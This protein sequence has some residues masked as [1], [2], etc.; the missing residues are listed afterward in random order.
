M[1]AECFIGF[2]DGASRHTCNLASA[3]W[4]IYSPLGQLVAS[5]DACLGA[6]TNN[7]VEYSVGIELLWDARLRGITCLE[8]IID[9]Q[10]V[11]SQLNGDYQVWN[12]NLLRQFLRVRLLERNFEYIAYIHISR[13]DNTITDAY[14]NYILDWHLTHTL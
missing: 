11:V 1:S 2:D 10:L 8:V 12:P 4:V 9:S 5:G 14:A 6:A 13:N 7:V 3:A